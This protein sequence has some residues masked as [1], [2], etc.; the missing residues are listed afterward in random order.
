MPEIFLSYCR[1][2]QAIARRFARSLE[3]EGFE[4]WWDD[5]LNPGETF[6]Q[7]TEAA[8]R[9]ARAVVVLWS[10]R[11]VA[12]RWVRSEATQAD[13]YGTLVP[14]T[15]EPCDRPI[16]FEL[17]HTAD[18]NGWS[19]ERND[20]CWRS[21]VERLRRFIARS[22]ARAAGTENI[23]APPAAP[24]PLHG[25]ARAPRKPTLRA[26]AAA[27]AA[28]AIAALVITLRVDRFARQQASGG[29]MEQLAELVRRDDYGPA[30]SLAI[31]MR[32]QPRV[33]EDERFQQLWK[34]IVLPMIPLVSEDGATVWFR[35]YD[36]SG[37]WVRAG[38]TPIATPVDAPRG[39]LR[40]KVEKP[41]FQ[42]SY[43][44]V[45]NPGLS[46]KTDP[47]L[48]PNPSP[49]VIEALAS[50][51]PL[52]LAREGVLD[53]GMVMVPASDVPVYVN[54]WITSTTGGERHRIPAFAVSRTEV[55]NAEYQE[56]VDAGGYDNPTYW[57][58]LAFHDG[59]RELTWE[60]ARDYFQDAS[61]EPGP[62][63]WLLGR[64]P[65]GA[66]N[67]PVGGISWYEARA[68]ARFSGKSLPTIHH[69][70]RYALSLEEGRFGTAPTIALGSR[71]SAT[72]PLPAA[73]EVGTGP[74]GTV[75]TAG[76]VREWVHNAA[77]TDRLALGGAWSDYA[78][79]YSYPL[80][81]SPMQRAPE[82][83]LRLMQPLPGMLIDEAL[84][85]PV[86]L[87]SGDDL[88][89]R[90]PEPDAVFE[91]MR[92]Q[93][94]ASRGPP[95][96]E[97][98][99]RVRESPEWVADKV[100]L[101]FAQN[102]QHTLYI[103]R[104]RQA[105]TPLQ[106]VIYAPSGDCCLNSRPNNETLDYALRAPANIVV[107]SGRALVMPIWDDSFERVASDP[108]AP[109][110]SQAS[111]RDRRLAL[112]WHQ[113]LDATLDYLARH[114]DFD[115]GGVALLAMSLGATRIA[116]IVLAIEGRIRTAVL[117][118]GGLRMDSDH[119]MRNPLHYLPRITMPV[120]MING[121]YDHIFGYDGARRQMYELLGTPEGLK[122]QI[123][124]DVGHFEYP[125]NS[126]A[127]DI[128]NW[129]DEHLGPGR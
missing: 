26:L 108:P 53:K 56:F 125:S 16:L 24:P 18:L 87:Q 105:R 74:W 58:G 100:V 116:P 40:V 79:L 22:E 96:N 103:V 97:S 98:V 102:Q 94:T 76:N 17:T 107:R 35:P 80:K 31:E 123:P 85:Q 82:N 72:S 91:M 25:T 2:E 89:G 126:L 60:E 92:L 99:E 78:S 37:G 4:V 122:K 32:K 5:A 36:E 7:V 119:E 84:F 121:R 20:E 71:F 49:G 128:D 81:V 55:T 48:L 65:D 104:P 75:H 44:V 23:P 113:D 101:D 112:S 46:V 86:K 6:D 129:L 69:W 59:D 9:E 33:R 57:Q 62:K 10:R 90:E 43:F 111:D 29:D 30:F 50:P 63:E 106:A 54:L 3:D 45:S 114:P 39:V 64:Y 52:P 73:D 110:T 120:L 68:Y 1:E 70:A 66:A 117:I 109:G 51:V 95:L 115:S 21:F 124:Y 93:F 28:I 47:A 19:G 12:S 15:I 8:L 13:R 27:M 38:V 41:G 77:G 11:S 88:S 61:G 34:Q 83:G 127:A 67:L 14:V 42:T 118:S